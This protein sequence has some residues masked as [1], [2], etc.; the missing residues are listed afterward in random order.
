MTVSTPDSD[1]T[2]LITGANGFIG[3]HTAMHFERHGIRIVP[4]DVLPRSNDLALLT[5]KTPSHLFDIAEPGRLADLCRKEKV[6]QILHF[7]YPAR[8]E[9]TQVLDFLLQGTRNVLEVAREVSMRRVVFSSSGA[10]YGPLRKGD[11]SRIRET[12]AVGIFPTFL[13]RSAKIL[14][15]WLG[16]FYAVHHG[17]S[18]VALRLSGV[19]G[20]GLWRDIGEHLKQGIIG[21]E[22]RPFLGREPF[23]DPVY[24]EDVARSMRLACFAEKPASRAYN[25]ASGRPYSN[26]DLSRAIRKAL[27]DLAFEIGRD[28]DPVRHHRQRDM[29]DVNLAKNELGFV[30]EYDLESGIRATGEWLMSVRDKL[31]R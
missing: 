28:P 29:L 30:P 24:V 14:G 2:V 3:T 7:A 12:D 16:D 27:P 5:V 23:D 9:A 18:F 10:I 11:G 19:Y 31:G 20:P 26:E 21:R 15:E 4:V 6:T 1:V 25:I 13:Y 17:V 8:K 22:C